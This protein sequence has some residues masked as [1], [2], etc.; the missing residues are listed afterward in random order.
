ASA[1]RFS[2][3]RS[4]SHEASCHANGPQRLFSGHFTPRQEFRPE[5]PDCLA[6]ANYFRW[7]PGRALPNYIGMT[8]YGLEPGPGSA[9]GPAYLGGKYA[10]FAVLGDPNRPGTKGG[11]EVDRDGRLVGRGALLGQ[12]E[13]RTGGA[14]PELMGE[15]QQ[16]ALDILSR[17]DARRAFDLDL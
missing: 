11:L 3:L 7:Q 14:A 6:I 17:P 12:L 9:I 10:P 15:F 4:L 1:D 5:H 2:L 8:T 16:Q 13:R